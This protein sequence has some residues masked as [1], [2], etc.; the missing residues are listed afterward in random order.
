[1]D[2]LHPDIMM[3]EKVC[4][5]RDTAF[6][7][8]RN[9]YSFGMINVIL[10]A[11]SKEVAPPPAFTDCCSISFRGLMKKACQ[12]AT[13][14]KIHLGNKDFFKAVYVLGD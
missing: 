4:V 7:K 8:Y 2:W 6:P 13:H 14:Y 12:I 5:R 11:G 3:Y 10:K 9:V 1:M